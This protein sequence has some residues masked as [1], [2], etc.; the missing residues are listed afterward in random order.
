MKCPDLSTTYLGLPLKNP[1]IIGASPLADKQN[2]VVA[3][4]QAG[5]SAIVMH[6]LFE[7]QLHQE[8]L[9][10]EKHVEDHED[11]F[12]EAAS[13]FPS[14]HEYSFEPNRYLQHLRWLK[15]TVGI[16]VIASLNGTTPGGWT[17]YAEILE[18][19]GAD[20]LELNFYYPAMRVDESG[21]EVERQL[22]D[23]IRDVRA[24]ISIPLAVK[25]SPFYTSFGHVARQAAEAGADGL[26]LFNRFYQPDI[27]PEQM[28]AK[29]VLQLSQSN[30]LL[31]RLRWL[32]ALREKVNVS[33]GCTG[34]VHHLEDVVKAILAGADAIQMVSCLLKHGPGYLHILLE[35]LKTWMNEHDYES[36]E[37]LKG[38][39]S[40]R[41]CPEPAAYERGN[42]LRILQGWQ[43]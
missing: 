33:L 14:I 36:V 10:M 43:S 39:M 13:Y 20:A 12:A 9:G 25:L 42:Y 5:A 22:V 15:K 16:P 35:R 27:D 3:L 17:H 7:E 38:A 18:D 34:G 41:N 4:E 32:A 40:M 26:V 1:F 21:A 24:V 31:L 2:T 19:A 37:Q 30:E 23:T 8:M 11:V 6:S 28:E 29:P